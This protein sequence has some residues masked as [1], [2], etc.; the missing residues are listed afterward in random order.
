MRGERDHTVVNVMTR[1]QNVNNTRLEPYK[2]N[3]CD[4][5]ARC[6]QNLI[7]VTCLFGLIAVFVVLILIMLKS[8]K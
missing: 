4:I 1:E 3:K 2:E 7:L 6:I 8:Y 5:V